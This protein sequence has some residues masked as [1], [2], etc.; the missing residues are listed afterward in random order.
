M[1]LIISSNRFRDSQKTPVF[2][3]WSYLSFF[4]YFYF[5]PGGNWSSK[6]FEIFLRPKNDKYA[7]RYFSG[8]APEISQ[9]KI[10]LVPLN[11]R[12]FHSGFKSF[13]HVFF[14]QLGRAFIFSFVRQALL[15]KLLLIWLDLNGDGDDDDL[16]IFKFKPPSPKWLI[17]DKRNCKR[18]TDDGQHFR[19]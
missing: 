7:K 4:K 13:S 14:V 5:F 2:G 6:K 16:L 8:L 19:A 9:K 12:I 18:H 10:F 17:F 3:N 11:L 15:F 1:I